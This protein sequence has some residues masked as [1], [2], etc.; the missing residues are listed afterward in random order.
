MAFDLN[1]PKDPNHAKYKALVAE[2]KKNGTNTANTFVEGL[3]TQRM[4][5]AQGTP[6]PQGGAPTPTAAPAALPP[7]AISQLK[8][9]PSPANRAYFDQIFGAGAAA[10]ALGG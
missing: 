5:A 8:A 6:A 9:D 3:V 2:D 7:A 1:S 10:K 4:A